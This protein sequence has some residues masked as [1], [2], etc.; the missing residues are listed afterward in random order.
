MEVWIEG[1]VG[2]L[3]G[4]LWESEEPARAAAVFCHPHPAHGGNMNSTVV[5]RSARALQAAGLDVLRFDFRGVRRSQGVH[6]G[7]GGEEEDLAAAL[8]WLE[9]LRPGLP[10]WAGGFSFGA[11]TVLGLA[12]REGERLERV[13]L[14][15]PPVGVY[16]CRPLLDLAVP[17][18]IV[19][20]AE[21]TFGTRQV[22]LERFPEL[23]QR[24][25]I[26]EIPQ[27]D[28]FFRGALDELGERVQAWARKQLS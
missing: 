15:A 12:A 11:R 16:G 8:D 3:H 22:L 1:P 25:S 13:L 20:A 27:A 23:A 10:L 21:D 19:M 14:V 24:M 6:D 2:R 17:G 9:A 18:L 28:H 4:E 7:Q 5:F 26:E